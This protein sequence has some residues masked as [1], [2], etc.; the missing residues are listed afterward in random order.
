MSGK[1]TLWVPGTDHAGIATQVVVEKKLMREQHKTRHDFGRDAFI[2]EV[3]KWKQASGNRICS[4]LRRLGTS[5]D[6]S[7]EVFTM[8]ETRS[9]AVE[10]A[11]LRLHANKL[12]TRANRLV[13][14]SC[15][16]RSAISSIEVDHIDLDK[17]TKLKVPGHS[18]EVEFGVIH[19]F[20]YPLSDGSGEL[21]VAT[22]RIETMLGDVAVAVHPEDERYKAFHGKT[23]KHPFVHDRV[24]TVIA[25]GELVDMKFG[26]GAVKVTPAHDP[27]DYTCGK[28]NKLQFVSYTHIYKHSNSKQVI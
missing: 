22:T 25:D 28:R 14:W 26:T 4:Q 6:W 7:R 10:E 15:A 3:W 9:K 18:K 2:E 24:V 8:D 13:N 16:L 17:P 11:F 20:A 19:S 21:V 1:N 23:L 12:I 27:N 5:V